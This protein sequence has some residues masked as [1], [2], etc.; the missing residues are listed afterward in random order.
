MASGDQRL[1]RLCKE[2]FESRY[3]A[4]LHVWVQHPNI[5][6]AAIANELLTGEP[7]IAI[8]I[9]LRIYDLR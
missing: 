1:C 5:H 2:A 6:P 8:D 9:V 4:Y 7:I 3:L